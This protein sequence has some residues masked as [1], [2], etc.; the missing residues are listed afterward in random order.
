MTAIDPEILRIASNVKQLV[1]AEKR[2]LARQAVAVEKARL[3]D[4]AL[5]AACQRVG[6]AMDLL[7]QAQFAGASEVPARRALERAAKDLS[8]VMHKQGRM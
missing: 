3:A 8:A 6:A 4:E 5:L 2:I 1:D 7:S